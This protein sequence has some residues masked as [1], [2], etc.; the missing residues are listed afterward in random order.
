MSLEREYPSLLIVDLSRF[1]FKW[2]RIS[3]L[4][5]ND[6]QN[7]YNY[8]Y[9]LPFVA[10]RKIMIDP[11]GELVSMD[12]IHRLMKRYL[13]DKKLRGLQWDHWPYIS[14]RETSI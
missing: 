12:L 8:V 7:I 14:E 6:A 9:F 3:D 5:Y 10:A 13:F 4:Q 11:K 2:G 1:F